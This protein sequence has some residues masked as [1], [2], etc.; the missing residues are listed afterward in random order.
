MPLP[1]NSCKPVSDNI[2]ELPESCESGAKTMDRLEGLPDFCAV[3][4]SVMPDCFT[5]SLAVLEK[6]N[7]L[8]INGSCACLLDS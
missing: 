7:W 2:R 3:I 1:W 6:S 8:I 5:A 4:F